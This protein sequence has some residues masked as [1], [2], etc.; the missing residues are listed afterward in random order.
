M[1]ARVSGRAV[2]VGGRAGA[3][4]ARGASLRGAGPRGEGARRPCVAG[5]SHAAVRDGTRRPCGRRVGRRPLTPAGDASGAAVARHAAV[6]PSTRHP[7][8]PRV[9]RRRG[10]PPRPGGP[11]GCASPEVTTCSRSPVAGV[12]SACGASAAGPRPRSVRAARRMRRPAARRTPGGEDQR[13]SGEAHHGAPALGRV[14]PA[15]RAARPRL[16]SSRAPPDLSADERHRPLAR[17]PALVAGRR[18]LG[19]PR[20]PSRRRHLAARRATARGGG[21]GARGP[22]RRGDAGALAAMMPA[23]ERWRLLPTFVGRRGLPRHRDRRGRHGHRRRR[24]RPRRA[25][26]L[27]ARPR[28]RRLPRREPGLEAPR[29]L[30][31]ALLRRAGAAPRLPGLAPAAGPRRPPPPVGAARPPRAGSSSSRRR[32]ASAARR[33]SPGLGGWDAV[34]LWRRHQDGDRAALRLLV[35]YN[36][37]DAVNLQ[38]LAALGYNRIVERL[39]LPAEPV[40]VA[41]RG[42]WLLD[43]TPPGPRTRMSPRSAPV[44]LLAAPPRR[45][46]AAG[47]PQPRDE[48]GRFLNLDPRETHGF[49]DLLRWQILDRLDGSKRRAPTAHRCPPWRPTGRGCARHRRGAR[50][51][52][53]PGSATR[54]SSSSSTGCRC[55]STRCW[56]TAWGRPA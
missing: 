32:R 27:P 52:A 33:T 4:G 30:Q 38:A 31:R 1:G 10:A 56:A 29:H 21:A 48:E 24:P 34:V 36:L 25:A 8:R 46:P 19:R 3:A 51:R 42:D 45:R 35:E 43:M 14:A 26:R 17:A 11:R 5:S 22:R 13:P 16:R 40:R 18:H 15:A 2:A 7:A 49:G 50:A 41:H 28:P 23:R 12:A 9:P 55:S 6:S 54:A 20:G 47:R 44:A 39:G 37:H 53:S